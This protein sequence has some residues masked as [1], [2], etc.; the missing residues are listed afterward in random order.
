MMMKCIQIS[1]S[2]EIQNVLFVSCL[3]L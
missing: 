2:P 1:L 3:S